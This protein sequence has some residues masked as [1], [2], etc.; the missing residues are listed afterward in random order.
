MAFHST[1]AEPQSGS[2]LPDLTQRYAERAKIRREEN[3]EETWKDHDRIRKLVFSAWLCPL[4][5]SLRE[6]LRT[7]Q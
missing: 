5:V 4:C 3:E 7:A 2:S 6:T 1:V